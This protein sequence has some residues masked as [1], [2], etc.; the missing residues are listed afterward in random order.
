[1]PQPYLGDGTTIAAAWPEVAPELELGPEVAAEALTVLVTVK[2]PSS[3][4]TVEA[5]Y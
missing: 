2:M 1:M 4:T 5:D 3:T